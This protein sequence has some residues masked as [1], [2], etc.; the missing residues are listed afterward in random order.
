MLAILRDLKSFETT[1]R[2]RHNL[3]METSQYP[4]IIKEG[5]MTAQQIMQPKIHLLLVPV[6]F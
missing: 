5:I 6:D 2:R 3:S 4:I 1:K